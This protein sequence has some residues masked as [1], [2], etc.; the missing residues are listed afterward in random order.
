MVPAFPLEEI[1]R[2]ARVPGRASP[3]SRQASGATASRCSWR[4]ACSS[5][6]APSRSSRR[7]R[8][9]SRRSRSRSRRR[10][11][12]RACRRRAARGVA[13]PHRRPAL[14]V[15][16]SFSP[17]AARAL[18]VLERGL[19]GGRRSGGARG[20]NELRD[21]DARADPRAA[22]ARGDRLRGAGRT[23]TRPRP[24]GRDRA[25]RRCR[26]DAYPRGAAALRRAL[27]DGR[28]TSSASPP[29][30]SADRA[31]AVEAR[32]AMRE[33]RAQALG[34]RLRARLVAA[35]AGGRDDAR[36]RGLRRRLPVA[37]AAGAGGAA[38]ARRADEQ[39]ARQRAR[40]PRRRAAR[41]RC[42]RRPRVRPGRAER[43]RR[44]RRPAGTCSTT[45]RPIVEAAGDGSSCRRRET[46]PV[47][48]APLARRGSGAADRRRRLRL[49]GRR[50]DEPPARLPAAGH[51]AAS[52]GSRCRATRET[53]ASPPATRDG[54]G[55]REIL[56]DGGIGG[57][58]GRRR[59]ARLVRRRDGDDRAARRRPRDLLRRGGRHRAQPRL[60]LAVPGLGAT[61]REPRCSTSR[62]RSA[63]SSCTT[64]SARRRARSRACRPG[65]AR[66][67]A[68]TAG[69]R[70]ARLV[71]PA[72]RL[73]RDGVEMPPAHAACLAMLEPVMTMREGARIY[74]PGGRLLRAGDALDQPG[75]VARSNSLADEGAARAYT[76]TIGAS[77]LALSDERGGLVTEAD[78][79]AY[80]ARWS[81][82]VE[83]PGAGGAS[84]PAAAFRG[85]PET[86]AR[87][88]RLRGLAGRRAC[89]RSSTRST[90]TPARRRT[91]RTSSRRLGGSACVLTTSLGLG[92]GDWLPGLDL[93]LNS[94]LG[95][96]DLVLGAL[97]PGARMAS[98]MAPTLVFDG[99]GLALASAP[100]AG[101]GCAPR[102][103]ASLAGDPRR[104]P[105]AA[106]G[107][108]PAARPPGRR[109]R[110]RR[111][112]RRRGGARRARAHADE[113][114]GAGRRGTTTSAASAR[115][116]AA[117]RRIRGGAARRAAPRQAGRDPAD[118]PHVGQPG[119]SSTCRRRRLRVD[120][121]HSRQ[122]T[123]SSP[124]HRS[125]GR[126]H[127]CRRRTGKTCAWRLRRAAR[128]PRRSTSGAICA[129]SAASDSNASSSRRRSQSS[130]TSRCP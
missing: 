107:G 119:Y 11:R 111:A 72:L 57:G 81:E 83:A 98:M 25:Q 121:P 103:S 116:A 33:P 40:A 20:R 94:M 123:R 58:R 36:S 26:V 70:G 55:R 42:R 50:A 114:S 13:Q 104:G 61:A 115:R 15:R 24:G 73:A 127:T 76:G 1:V 8:F 67:G 52:A 29:T 80:E 9:A 35:G 102:S 68:R 3:A 130:T 122:R 39:L 91:R 95:E 46:D 65:S 99:D 30:I 129:T 45:R 87:L 41:A 120:P 66:C 63:R 82:P 85:V 126:L 109:R 125:C 28:A 88:P 71:E 97:E 12:S 74:A 100:P 96:V 69:S 4:T 21:G 89:S 118:V 108:R 124:D 92:S 90:A 78:L 17:S 31:A 2:D 64:R 112:R 53:A 110:E 105:R 106:G 101:R 18:L 56:A 51:R 23:R 16:P 62:C 93:H 19:L 7:R 59:G 43:E 117:P 47:T 86:L 6:G 60:L 44:A 48:G 79:A 5:W 32:A 27:V 22:R 37:A 34:A 54:G 128:S 38:R 77:L 113:P 10:S 14:R 49:R 84:S 75:L